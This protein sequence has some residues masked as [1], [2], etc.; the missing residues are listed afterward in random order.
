M[1]IVNVSDKPFE[2]MFDQV[3]YGPYAPGQ[4]VDLPEHIAQHGLVKSAVL[5][6]EGMGNIVDFKLK[7]LAEARVTEKNLLIYECP[8]VSSGECKAKAFSSVDDLKAHMESHWGL[9]TKLSADKKSQSK[10]LSD[11]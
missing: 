3:T 7:T 10:G 1:K 8:L 5:D 9:A 4:I 11:L 2:F 6:D